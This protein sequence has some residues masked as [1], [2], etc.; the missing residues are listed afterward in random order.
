MERDEESTR[1]ARLLAAVV[2][3][4][5]QDACI[6]PIRKGLQAKPNH[7]A[8]DAMSFIYDGYAQKYLEAIG[9]S[10][11]AYIQSLNRE[12]HKREPALPKAPV[13]TDQKRCFCWNKRWYD[14]NKDFIDLSQPMEIDNDVPNRPS[15]KAAPQPSQRSKVGDGNP[16]LKT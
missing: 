11:E 4:A 12:M 15:K 14:A 13:S 3:Q 2:L 6:A 10:Y 16:L 5:I 1:S 8:I 9:M 7:M